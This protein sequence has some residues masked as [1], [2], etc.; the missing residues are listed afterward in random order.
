M[1]VIDWIRGHRH[2]AHIAAPSEGMGGGSETVSRASIT[3]PRAGQAISQCHILA[4]DLETTGLDPRRDHIVSLGYVAIR[5][6]AIA[7]G[8]A[9]HDVVSDAASAPDLKSE[10]HGLTHGQLRS[11]LS[12]SAALDRLIS[13]LDGHI[14]LA[15]NSALELG[16]LSAAAPELAAGLA[17]WPVIDTMHLAQ[18]RL[19]MSGRAARAGGLRLSSLRRDYGLPH[20][21]MHNALTDAISAAELF[22]AQSAH[23][24]GRDSASHPVRGATTAALRSGRQIL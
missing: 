14:L 19:A 6:G 18:R 17:D 8:T 12:L 22:L 13:A 5:G 4:I 15:H 10:I 9:R 7:L 23:S 21:Q 1:G 3:W 11:G 2:T 20:R 24:A 16:F